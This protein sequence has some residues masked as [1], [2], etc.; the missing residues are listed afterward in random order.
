MIRLAT[1]FSGIG[2]PEEALKQLNEEFNIVF[3]CDN[4]E[5][6][7]KVTY[8][9][10]IEA[11]SN[12]S[13]DD[14]LKYV[15][16]LYEKTNKE[17]YVK[18]SYFAN[19]DIDETRWFEDVRF[20]DG[21]KYTGDVDILVGGSPCQSFSTYGKKQGFEDTRGTLFFFYANLVKKIRPKV[22]IYENVPGLKTHDKGNAWKRIQ[23]IFKELDYDIYDDVLNASDYGLPQN[24]E[25]V[26]VV[27]FDK[28]LG[29]TD[30]CFPEKIKLTKKTSD[31]LEDSVPLSYYLGK[32]GYEWVTT[33]EKHQGRSR[34]NRDII[35][36]QT[37]NQ[38]FNWTGDF[39]LESPSEEMRNDERIFVGN[40]EGKEC[41]ARKLTPAE[42]LR[43]MGFKNFKI[44]V[45][46]NNAYR[47]SGNSIAVPVLKAL[48]KSIISKM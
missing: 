23:E 35:G 3:A 2:A 17:N 48:F 10:I 21:E 40:Y 22:F 9:E 16:T 28:R 46:D 41:V 47:Q 32:K 29:I 25:R 45:N 30:Y 20:I 44:V 26:F 24:R 15:S 36:C 18:Q 43:L 4:G 31:Y 1:V 37:A 19:H 5:R 42:C 11:T 39:R 13:Y 33:R 27:G 34:V 38:Q 7:L 8:D 12:M 6:E 14:R